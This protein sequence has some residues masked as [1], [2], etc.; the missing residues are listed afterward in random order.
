METRNAVKRYGAQSVIGRVLSVE[1]I[2]TFN[3]I[4]VIEKAFW[5]RETAQDKATWA[6]ANKDLHE[7][8][9]WA[10]NQWRTE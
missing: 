4:D 1:E 7:L 9:V 2:R 5:E 6:K 3:M 8:L 10:R